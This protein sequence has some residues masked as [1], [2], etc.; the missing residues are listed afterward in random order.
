[1]NI[2]KNEL[3]TKEEILGWPKI[4]LGFYNK[5]LWKNRNEIFG[6]PN[7][8]LKFSVHTIKFDLPQSN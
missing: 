6:Q 3:F 4:L 5:I 8:N 1:M 2:G 7:I